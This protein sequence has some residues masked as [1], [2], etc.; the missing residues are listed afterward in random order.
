MKTTLLPCVD[1][2]VLDNLIGDAFW[3]KD[4]HPMPSDCRRR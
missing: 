3:S 4:T 1:T 2:A